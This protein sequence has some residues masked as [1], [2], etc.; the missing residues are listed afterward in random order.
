MQGKYNNDIVLYKSQRL[1]WRFWIDL[2]ICYLQSY[3]IP[4]QDFHKHLSIRS[5]IYAAHENY[6]GIVADDGDQP[7]IVADL[8]V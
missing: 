1:H 8:Q 2:E 3:I 5:Y 4:S 7:D 6:P